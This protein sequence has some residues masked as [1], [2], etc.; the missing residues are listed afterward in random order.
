VGIRWLVRAST[1]VIVDRAIEPTQ[2]RV[3]IAVVNGELLV[4]RLLREGK[5]L[6]LVADNPEY[7]PLQITAE[8]DFQTW[9]VVTNVVFGESGRSVLSVEQN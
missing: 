9:G 7:P 5:R 2:G 4:K 3:I 6:S 1:L 8:T